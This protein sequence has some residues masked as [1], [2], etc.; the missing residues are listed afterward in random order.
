HLLK[1]WRCL[2]GRTHPAAT[3]S[4]AALS[5]HRHTVSERALFRSP[6]RA[7]PLLAAVKTM[8]Q[9]SRAALRAFF[10]SGLTVALSVAPSPDRVF[11]APSL[12]SASSFSNPAA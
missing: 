5:S 2:V 3:A 4:T 11:P 7:L 8:R 10:A 1:H 9:A 12:Q 6:A